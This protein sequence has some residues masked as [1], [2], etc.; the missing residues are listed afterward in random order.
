MKIESELSLMTGRRRGQMENGAA[1]VRV[2]GRRGSPIAGSAII[3]FAIVVPLFFLLVFAV[4]DMASLFYSQT[5]LQ[6]AVRTAGRYAM[7][8]QH[9]P[10]G[11]G[12]SLSRVNSIIQ[13]AQQQAM[14]LNISNISVSSVQGGSGSAGGPGDTV[15]ISLT[16]N[17]QLLTPFMSQF[18]RNGVYTFT[19]STRFKNESFPPDQTN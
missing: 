12:G 8:G 3:E 17:V 10:D 13:V 7:T 1:E 14:G 2:P 16:S 18:F 15:L 11:H 6:D 5:T 4:V 9:Q 19:V